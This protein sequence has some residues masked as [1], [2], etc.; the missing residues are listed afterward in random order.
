MKD[1]PIWRLPELRRDPRGALRE[2]LL[3]AAA[4]AVTI[5]ALCLW[6]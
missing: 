6:G 5:L 1:E 4:V 3:A 2:F